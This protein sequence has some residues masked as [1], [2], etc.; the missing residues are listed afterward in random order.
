MHPSSILYKPQ[1]VNDGGDIWTCFTYSS[2]VFAVCKLK[3]ILVYI[4]EL[5]THVAHDRSNKVELT[6]AEGQSFSSVGCT[7][8]STFSDAITCEKNEI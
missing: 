2:I 3:K 1:P 6:S 7:F 8:N 5:L 4:H